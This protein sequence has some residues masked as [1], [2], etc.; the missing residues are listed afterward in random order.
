MD[1]DHPQ[2]PFTYSTS[3][4]ASF[5]FLG[6]DLTSSLNEDFQ[7]NP[8][9]KDFPFIPQNVVGVRVEIISASYQNQ[10]IIYK[11]VISGYINRP[12]PGLE[13]AKLEKDGK[14]F[15]SSTLYVLYLSLIHISEPTRPY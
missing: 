4:N 2:S 6:N 10:A 8:T 9:W 7:F 11:T 15:T 12:G 14:L 13:L 3:S 1:K 5:D